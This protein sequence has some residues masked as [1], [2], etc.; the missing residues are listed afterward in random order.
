MRRDGLA[1]ARGQTTKRNAIV[2]N[3]F[4]P[5]TSEVRPSLPKSPM[6]RST[7]VT[8]RP[9]EN[10]DIMWQEERRQRKVRRLDFEV[11]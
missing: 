3:V 6:T 8:A 7:S 5:A 9:Q 10:D 1:T 11:R 2:R 4:P